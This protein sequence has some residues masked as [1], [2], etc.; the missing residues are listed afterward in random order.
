[1][2]IMGFSFSVINGLDLRSVRDIRVYEEQGYVMLEALVTIRNSSGKTV[3]I[4]NARFTLVVMPDE[5]SSHPLGELPVEEALIPY[6]PEG[7][8]AHDDVVIPILMKLGSNRSALR[9]LAEALQHTLS[10]NDRQRLSLGL[11][12]ALDL[13]IQDRGSWVYEERFTLDWTLSPELETAHLNDV[14]QSVI[15]PP[16]QTSRVALTAS[17]TEMPT[18]QPVPVPPTPTVNSTVMPKI[19]IEAERGLDGVCLREVC[20]ECNIPCNV[21]QKLL[22][23]TEHKSYPDE[24]TLRRALSASFSTDMPA[25]KKN[26]MTC[27][28]EECQIRKLVVYFRFDE[29]LIENLEEYPHQL[30]KVATW[31]NQHT[32]IKEPLILYINGYADIRGTAVYNLQLSIKRAESVYRYLTQHFPVQWN[33][34]ECV[35]QGFGEQFLVSQGSDELSHQQNR[36]VELYLA[37]RSTR[38]K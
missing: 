8:A 18:P 19:E 11:K 31:A 28:T 38:P 22:Q 29:S 9:A 20:N 24:D 5:H 26:A 1:M 2:V 7:D 13:G 27:L 16:S 33:R 37:R 35:V 4:K 3:H 10:H 36:R 23:S 17:P 6:A 12:G 30:E 34:D 15:N 14:L 32:V 25:L 21:C